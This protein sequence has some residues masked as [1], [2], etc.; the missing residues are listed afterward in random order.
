[1]VGLRRKQ[2]L[3]Q[4]AQC[5][6]AASDKQRAVS[7]CEANKPAGRFGYD[8][9]EALMD[10]RHVSVVLRVSLTTL[11]K[12]RQTGEGPPA[13]HLGGSIYRYAR[14]DFDAFLQSRST[15]PKRA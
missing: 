5:L 11:A 13:V 3:D 1:M 15:G 6:S 10:P 8:D 9:S 7:A 14:G 2:A 4:T 12:W